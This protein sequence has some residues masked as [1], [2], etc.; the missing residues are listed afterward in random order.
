MSPT[1]GTRFKTVPLFSDFLFDVNNAKQ[2]FNFKFNGS[3]ECGEAAP[4]IVATQLTIQVGSAVTSR[5]FTAPREGL[6]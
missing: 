2:Q 6:Y 4:A 1:T 3:L 5:S